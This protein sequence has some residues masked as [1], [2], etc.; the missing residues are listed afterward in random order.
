[1]PYSV[2]VEKTVPLS[3]AKVFAALMD[4]GAIAKLAPDAIATCRVEGSGV[5]AIR[6]FTLKGD[7]TEMAERLE[8]A[9]DERVFSYSLIT[10]NS[11][12]LDHY[13]AVV[14][15]ADAP[16]GGCTVTWGSNWKSLKLP[17]A[18]LK[19]MLSQLYVSL[20]DAIVAAG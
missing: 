7:P 16:G 10:P 13:H 4:F 15:L 2:S 9:V 11:L 8:C 1:M 6:T 5:G 20:I 12:G 14:I 17:E 3:R 18:E 19:P